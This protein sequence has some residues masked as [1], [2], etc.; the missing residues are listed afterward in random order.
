ML[1]A[2]LCQAIRRFSLDVCYL[3][4]HIIYNDISH[5]CFT[6]V[7]CNVVCRASLLWKHLGFLGLLRLCGY[8]CFGL[9]SVACW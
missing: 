8:S 9:M 5:A 1:Y 3:I 2:V 7:K 6:G 4:L